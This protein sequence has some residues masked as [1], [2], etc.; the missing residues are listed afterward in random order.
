MARRDNRPAWMT[1]MEAEGIAPP[2]VA[3]VPEPA[4]AIPAAVPVAP[5]AAARAPE[6]RADDDKVRSVLTWLALFLSSVQQLTLSWRNK[7]GVSCCCVRRRTHIF[8]VRAYTTG[9]EGKEAQ[10]QPRPK[11]PRP[12]P[13]RAP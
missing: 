3:K 5:P 7:L 10:P 12:S 11:R 6:P 9:Q 4:M 1:K 2:V 8:G 13:V